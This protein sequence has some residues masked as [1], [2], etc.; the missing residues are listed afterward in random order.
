MTGELA[1][2]LTVAQVRDIYFALDALVSMNVDTCNDAHI[3]L[4]RVIQG[5]K[6]DRP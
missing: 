3:R 2:T 5:L 6:L 4:Y 1:V